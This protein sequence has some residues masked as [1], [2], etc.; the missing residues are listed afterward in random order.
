MKK[1]FLISLMMLFFNSLNAQIGD[2]EQKGNWLYSYDENGKS[3]GSFS[4]NSS[5]EFLGFS[6]SLIVIKK[7]SWLNSYDAKGSYL[8]ALAIGSNDKFKSVTG[9]NINIIKGN[10]I[11]T[12][13]FK[14]SYISSRN[15]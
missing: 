4:I 6:T 1:L 2:V 3:I 11:Y 9:K 8:G 7:G 12:Y 5:D 13:D 14:G 10:W 15:L